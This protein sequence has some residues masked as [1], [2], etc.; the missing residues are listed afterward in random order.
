MGDDTHSADCVAGRD[1]LVVVIVH[2]GLAFAIQLT[3]FLRGHAFVSLGCGEQSRRADS[4]LT[5]THFL[6]SA[7]SVRTMS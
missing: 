7:M 4:Y 3:Y 6:A 1:E 5:S 2:E